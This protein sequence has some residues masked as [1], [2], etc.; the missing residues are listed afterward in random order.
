[1][2]KKYLNKHLKQ[3]NSKYKQ[4]RLVCI[5]DMFLQYASFCNLSDTLFPNS[6]NNCFFTKTLFGMCFFWHTFSWLISTYRHF[7][8]FI[9]SVINNEYAKR[10]TPTLRQ[11]QT[12]LRTTSQSRNHYSTESS[13]QFLLYLWNTK[14]ILILSKNTRPQYLVYLFHSQMHSRSWWMNAP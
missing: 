9:I 4:N 1:M 10:V 2:F 13:T 12:D 11:F 14:L 8:V 3:I 7:F 5:L 6:K